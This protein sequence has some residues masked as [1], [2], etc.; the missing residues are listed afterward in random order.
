MAKKQLKQI[1]I[2][3]LSGFVSDDVIEKMVNDYIIEIF[4]KHGNYPRI[5]TNSRFISVICDC[6]V[7]TNMS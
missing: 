5:E 7:D 4:N 1:K 2:F 6:F 3:R